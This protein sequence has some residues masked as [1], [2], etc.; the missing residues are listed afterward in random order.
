MHGGRKEDGWWA[1]GGRLVVPTRPVG[2]RKRLV[3][4]HPTELTVFAD[5]TADRGMEECDGT[6]QA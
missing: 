1:Q 3:V 5:D 2:G 4:G 6:L